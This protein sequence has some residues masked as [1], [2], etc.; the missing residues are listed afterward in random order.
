MTGPNEPN[1]GTG[2]PPPVRSAPTLGYLCDLIHEL[3][4]LADRSGQR[5]LSAILAAALV[6]ARIQNDDNSH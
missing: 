4:H 1:N 6:E 2:Q 5:T 3:K